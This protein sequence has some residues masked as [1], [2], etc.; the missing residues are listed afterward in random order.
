MTGE[1]EKRE[2]A[3]MYGTTEYN[4]RHSFRQIHLPDQTFT[5]TFTH[6]KSKHQFVPSAD[7]CQTIV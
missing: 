2:E 7:H 3:R 1:E 5:I 4:L 6:L